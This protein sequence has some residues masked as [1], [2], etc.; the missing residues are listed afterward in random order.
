MT[1][2]YKFRNSINAS[3]IFISSVFLA[4]CNWG[5]LSLITKYLEL[6]EIGL[7]T[8]I[9][10]ISNPLFQFFN[11]QLRQLVVTDRSE[12]FKFNEYFSVRVFL[13]SIVLIIG[14]IIGLFFTEDGISRVLFWLIFANYALDAIIDIF[15]AQMHFYQDYIRISKSTFLRG[16][17]AIL[18]TAIGLIFLESLT[19]SFCL[20]ILFKV[21]AA[22][23]Y[24]LKL[25]R[26]LYI[27]SPIIL[28]SS[29]NLFSLIK[30]GIPLGATLFVVSMNFNMS[31]YFV[32]YYY[33]IEVQ[34]A[35][36]SM[37][38]L[39]VL[40]TLFVSTF[41]QL[42]LPKMAIMFQNKNFQK[43]RNT[44]YLYLLCTLILGLTLSVVSV[45]FGKVFIEIFFSSKISSFSHLFP[46]I[47]A[48]SLFVY[49]ASAQGYAL[50][51]VSI[52]RIQPI[53][54]LIAL[55][56][57]LLLNFVLGDTYGLEGMI[58]FSGITF[59]VQF[60]LSFVIFIIKTKNK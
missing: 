51:S 22:F 36:S 46:Y 30:K 21:I 3:S 24:D 28:V 26:R 50:T 47:M 10:A 25:I 20:I 56:V 5:Q 57:N 44:H 27:K 40:G 31:K 45:P 38:Y 17:A 32:D 8:L 39:I 11:L 48:S 43:L 4:L 59:C 55:G 52:L 60:I 29:E 2:S 42:L 49:L 34:G 1:F 23:F 14:G 54:S 19:A 9:L 33:G 15:N 16:G 41:G 53:I 35:F 13:S 6:E 58:L 18:G 7:Y 37:S 12:L